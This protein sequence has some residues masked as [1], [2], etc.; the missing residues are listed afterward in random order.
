MSFQKTSWNNL[1]ENNFRVCTSYP[2]LYN[3]LSLNLATLE[4]KNVLSYTFCG[5][6]IQ[7]LSLE[8]LVQGLSK[9]F[10][11]DLGH[12]HLKACLGKESLRP[13]LLPGTF[14]SSTCRPSFPEG[15]CSILVTCIWL[16]SMS[17]PKE[18]KGEVM[19]SFR[20][21][22]QKSHCVIQALSYWHR[23][24]PCLMQEQII[25]ECEYQGSMKAI[26]E[27]GHHRR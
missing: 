17:G 3:K 24:M 13:W 10:S 25:Q 20:T 7:V 23:D 6:G 5:S 21:Y 14:S 16:S 12:C 18:N 2:L 15:C 22:P 9:G 26:Q 1:M 11:K 19:I 8:V 4:N 27:A